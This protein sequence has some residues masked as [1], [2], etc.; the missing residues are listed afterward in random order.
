M[1][2]D[3]KYIAMYESLEKHHKECLYPDHPEFERR[4][5]GLLLKVSGILLQPYREYLLDI[6]RESASLDHNPNDL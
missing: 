4:K 1:K 2:F 3:P 6:K 5:L